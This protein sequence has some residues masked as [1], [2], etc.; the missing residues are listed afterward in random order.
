MTPLYHGAAS[1]VAL[2]TLSLTP[3]ANAIT[4]GQVDDFED[5]TLQ[6]WNS[7]G[8]FGSPSPNPPTV[9][10]DI[11]YYASIPG[12]GGSGPGRAVVIS[13]RD[14]WSGDYLAAGVT[15]IQLDVNN[16]GTTDLHLRLAILSTAQ[17]GGTFALT[18]SIPLAPHGTGVDGWMTV[19]FDL[20]PANWTAAVGPQGMYAGEDILTALSSVTA[21][22]ILS[23]VEAS[24][25]G[26]S[27]DGRLGVD[28]ISAVPEPGTFALVVGGLAFLGWRRSA[29]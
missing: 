8:E 1:L 11:D 25:Q 13:N 15:S 17:G 10:Q 3:S 27:V 6:G 19:T 14:Q 23:S 18:E 24:Y 21:L 12:S 9:E 7:G 28:N 5:A 20:D 2:L 16:L 4:L 29:A 22:R 26:D